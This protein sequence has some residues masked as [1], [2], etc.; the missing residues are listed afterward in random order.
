MTPLLPG[1]LVL[2]GYLWLG[3]FGLLLGIGAAIA[4]IVWWRRSNGR[5]FY[6]RDVEQRAF[7]IS[8]ALTVLVFVLTIVA[9]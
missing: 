8:I 7:Y 9:I 3:G 5:K 4:W 1:T 6:P 2:L